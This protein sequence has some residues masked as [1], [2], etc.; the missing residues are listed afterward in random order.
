MDQLKLVTPYEPREFADSKKL[1]KFQTDRTGRQLFVYSKCAEVAVRMNNFR[2][3]DKIL[4]LYKKRGA[5]AR[6]FAYAGFVN[7]E[8]VLDQEKQEDPGW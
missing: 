4:T 1:C 6:W 3:V 7:G 2:L 5:N 8:L